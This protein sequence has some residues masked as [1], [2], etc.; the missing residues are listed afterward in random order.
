MPVRHRRVPEFAPGVFKASL[1][2]GQNAHGATTEQTIMRQYTHTHISH[3][4]R[5]IIIIIIIIS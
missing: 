2:H 5:A 4:S 3:C 1:P